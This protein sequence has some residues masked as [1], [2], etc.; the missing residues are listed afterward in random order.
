MLDK[1]MRDMFE[2]I[3]VNEPLDPVEAARR[4]HAAAPA[5]ALLL[6]VRRSS[7]RR[8]SVRRA[9]STAAR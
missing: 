4:A 2:D 7:R 1:S 9:C 5:P 6:S 3:F 8:R